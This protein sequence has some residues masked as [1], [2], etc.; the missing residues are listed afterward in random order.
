MVGRFLW[1][2]MAA[3]AVCG[4]G[5]RSTLLDDGPVGSGIGG[6]IGGLGGTSSG[7][8]DAGLGG[9]PS[10]G[11]TSGGGGTAGT[12]GIAGTGGTAGTGGSAGSGGSIND[13]ASLTPLDPVL[14][15][16]Q[17]S[18]EDHRSPAL[19]YL[20]AD[21]EKVVV[22][23]VPQSQ[24][25]FTPLDVATISAWEPWPSVPGLNTKHF[26]IGGPL[27]PADYRAWAT[28]SFDGTFS[29]GL[30][31]QA[32]F[33]SFS[34]RS[35]D[36]SWTQ[37]DLSKC[38]PMLGDFFAK[39]PAP[40]HLAATFQDTWLQVRL[41]GDPSTTKTGAMG[42][43]PGG[44]VA[45]AVGHGDGWLVAHSN[46]P[47]LTLTDCTFNVPGPATVIEIERVATDVSVTPVLKIKESAP[48][49]AVQTVGHPSGLYV[50]WRVVSGGKS[51][52]IRIAR[53]DVSTSSVVGPVDLTAPSDAPL[54]GFSA[55]AIGNR[56]AVAWGNDDGNGGPDIVVSVAD[57]NGTVLGRGT[58]ADHFSERVSAVGSPNGDSV[59]V[60]WAEGPS[61]GAHQVK[62]ARFDC[63]AG[64]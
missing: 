33:P 55:T 23:F 40:L 5:S 27:L 30:K 3:V 34:C 25:A 64:N 13:C 12:G 26:N 10:G 14:E 19:T 9:A 24:V 58:L 37:A 28:E 4:C 6:A 54:E 46:S 20:S 42:C 59:V 29:V 53:V 2:G 63:L 44:I 51:A 8:A 15:L 1:V 49:A 17:L 7:G 60:G 48:I 47:G 18:G 35:F 32:P 38:F 39:G 52:P 21:H 45:S 62:L 11:G 31:A 43:T 36:P 61:S 57:E 41:V 22:A 56:L 50:V 16:E